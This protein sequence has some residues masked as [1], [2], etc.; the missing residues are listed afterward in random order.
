[1]ITGMFFHFLSSTINKLAIQNIILKRL[2]KNLLS[3][4][5]HLQNIYP[6]AQDLLYTKTKSFTLKTNEIHQFVIFLIEGSNF[7]STKDTFLYKNLEKQRVF[8]LLTTK[9]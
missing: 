6:K 8:S 2:S 4:H 9:K 5:L 1:M 3:K 7:S